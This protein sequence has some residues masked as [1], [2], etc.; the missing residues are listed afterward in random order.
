MGACSSSSPPDPQHGDEHTDSP[1]LQPTEGSPKKAYKTDSE[2]RDFPKVL[3]LGAGGSGKSTLFKQ[4]LFAGSAP[5]DRS[6]HIPSIH[7]TVFS[8]IETLCLKAYGVQAED[9]RKAVLSLSD[10]QRVVN[11]MASRY[12]RSL[13]RDPGI[14]AAFVETSFSP[15]PLPENAKY[16]L[17]NVDMFSSLEYLP[18]DEDLLKCYARTTGIVE[19]VALINEGKYLVYDMGGQRAERKKWKHVFY[20]S[21]CFIFIAGLSDYHQVMLEDDEENRLAEQLKLFEGLLDMFP[22]KPIVLLLSKADL[23]KEKL[24]NPHAPRV[25][26]IFLD[27]RNDNDFASVTEW[28]K[29]QFMMR[30]KNAERD[31]M[32]QVLNLTDPVEVRSV[33]NLVQQFLTRTC[34]A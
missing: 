26:S 19:Y 21:S 14:Q 20:D 2:K 7:H 33:M 25:S 13:W 28:F 31:I 32:V 12:I 5:L 16:F 4:L 30:N 8:S 3:L 18:N 24:E 23:L 11:G 1:V 17:D 10:S 22:L 15:K 9:A 34:D 6:D 27:Y 29:R